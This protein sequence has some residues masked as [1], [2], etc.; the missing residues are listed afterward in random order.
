VIDVYR[1]VE[2]QTDLISY[3]A[4]QDDEKAIQL[5]ILIELT[6]PPT[7]KLGWHD[8]FATPFRYNLPVMS[9][10]QARFKPPFFNKNVFYCS[11]IIETALYEYSYHFMRQ[12]NHLQKSKRRVKNETG[13]RT[14]FSVEADDSKA[15]RLHLLNNLDGILHKTNLSDS[16]SYVLSN[17]THEFIIYPSVRDPQHRDSMAIMN[18]LHLSKTLKSERQLSFFYDYK[19]KTITWINERLAISW[20]MIY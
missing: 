7:L 6:K 13:T 5:E 10:Y 14:G 3:K 19:K 20:G 16:H 17:P 15:I 9:K 12:R 11:G 2:N 1:V 4:T 8:L 18:I